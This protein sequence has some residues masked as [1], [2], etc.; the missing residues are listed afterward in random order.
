MRPLRSA[1]HRTPR[2]AKT[3]SS[4]PKPPADP[5]PKRW[6]HTAEEA[7]LL[8]TTANQIAHIALA[9][10]T[11]RFREAG[12]RP[13]VKLSR[14]YEESVEHLDPSIRPR[15][16]RKAINYV[17]KRRQPPAWILAGNTFPRP[18]AKKRRQALRPRGSREYATLAMRADEP[19]VIVPV[20]PSLSSVEDA[21]AE[22]SDNASRWCMG[23]IEPG[24]LIA[25]ACVH[26]GQLS[27]IS[28]LTDRCACHFLPMPRRQ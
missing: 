8:W 12:F 13:T 15:I 3:T 5:P 21:R 10:R 27:L 20:R 23:D 17:P 26:L 18:P 11:M 24:D 4:K 6:Q 2:K 25:F 7:K 28:Q 9:G 22:W 14:T 1:A 19:M 16:P